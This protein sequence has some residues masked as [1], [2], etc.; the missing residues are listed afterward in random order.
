MMAP[1]T[2][3]WPAGALSL[4]LGQLVCNASWSWLFFARRRGALALADVLLLLGLII[5]T[6]VAFARV[7][8]LAA[9]LLLPY[10]AWATFA[11]ALTHAVW[12][13]NIDQLSPR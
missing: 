11:A 1:M 4:F 8:P 5:T 6:L 9:V 13:A 7:Q 3:L 2:T 10:L 12:R